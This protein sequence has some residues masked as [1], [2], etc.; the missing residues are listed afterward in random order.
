VAPDASDDVKAANSGL[1]TTSA[2]GVV[3]SLAFRTGF[4]VNQVKLGLGAGVYIACAGTADW[5]RHPEADVKYPGAYDGPQRWSALSTFMLVVNY[6]AG[7]SATYKWLSIGGAVTYGDAQ[8]STTKAANPGNTEELFNESGSVQEGRVFLDDATGGAPT[9]NVG[10]RADF[11]ELKLG[12]AYRTSTI[13]ELDGVAN[14]IYSNSESTTPAQVELQVANSFL[15]SVAYRIDSLT[16]RVEHE[17][18]GWSVMDQQEIKNG[19]DVLLVLERNF[20]DSHAYRLRFDYAFKAGLIAHAGISYEEGVTPEAYHEPGLAEHDQLEGGLGVTCPLGDSL[21]LH[22][23]FFYQHFFDRR[24]ARSAQKPTTNGHYT[25]H[26]QYL[27]LNLR[28]RL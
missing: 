22:S 7:L 3:P 9:F 24:V 4:D 13:Y 20:K 11:D 8:L 15:S 19:K 21:S 14:I 18:Q 6:A 28:W 17:L 27:T 2:L 16:L 25:D 1:G 12:F 10:L 23:T 5:D 26:R